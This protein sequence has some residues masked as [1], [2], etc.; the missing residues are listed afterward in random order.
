MVAQVYSLKDRRWSLSLPQA[1]QIAYQRENEALPL[2]AHGLAC[3]DSATLRGGW[4]LRQLSLQ[5]SP[6]CATLTHN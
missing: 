4:V 6:P 1:Q 2:Q 5:G 3:S